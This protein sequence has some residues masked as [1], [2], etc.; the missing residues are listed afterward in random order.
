MANIWVDSL[1]LH[2][3]D[4]TGNTFDPDEGFWRSADRS[5]VFGNEG[6]GWRPNDIP[7]SQKS[8]SINGNQALLMRSSQ[9]GAPAGGGSASGALGGDSGGLLA[10][11]SGAANIGPSSSNAALNYMNAV[12]TI[13]PQ[14]YGQTDP[15]IVRSLLPGGPTIDQQTLNNQNQQFGQNLGFQRDQLAQQAALAR[16]QLA[17]TTGM[18]R[19]DIELRR[20][21]GLAGID[22]DRL[23]L[24]LDRELGRGN[25]DLGRGQ[26]SLS[27]E[28]GRRGLA[29][30]ERSLA[31]NTRLTE[32]NQ[33]LQ[34]QE[35]LASR[36]T[37]QLAAPGGAVLP[38]LQPIM[39]RS[40]I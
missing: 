1:G 17:A 22:M 39:G 21:L 27:R 38:S 10:L 13:N 23:R 33:R 30:D 8:A 3:D 19:E 6:E 9:G 25:L 36:A 11:L 26:L 35:M 18:S 7:L 37:R 2:V 24:G 40:R 12:G 31:E 34:G 15:S 28:L 32:R 16:E 29:L 4:Q 5:M 14:V 20:M